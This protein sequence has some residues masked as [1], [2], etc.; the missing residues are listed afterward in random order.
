MAQVAISNV[1]QNN[2]EHF[3]PTLAVSGDTPRPATEESANALATHEVIVS[4][5]VA[6]YIICPF[7]II[8]HALSNLFDGKKYIFWN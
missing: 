5:T 2:T 4:G 7:L 3:D 8:E 6:V 1:N